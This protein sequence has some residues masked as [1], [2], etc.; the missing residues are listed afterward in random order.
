LRFKFARFANGVTKRYLHKTHL[1][2]NGPIFGIAAAGRF[3]CE[4]LRQQRFKLFHGIAIRK[5]VE[6]TTYF[7]RVQLSHFLV[8]ISLT[9]HLFLEVVLR[10]KL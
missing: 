9:A 8:Q 3:M 7:V 4:K 2:K 5:K 6:A 10:Q 1:E